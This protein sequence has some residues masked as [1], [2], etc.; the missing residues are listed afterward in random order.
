MKKSVVIISV[1]V[2][3]AAVAVGGMA[4][5]RR[6]ETA[7][8][9]AAAT[10]TAAAPA[11]PKTLELAASDLI[12]VAPREMRRTLPLTGQLRPSSQAVVRAK[13]AGE[14]VEM[15]VREGQAVKAG[16]V[17][18]RLEAADYKARVDEKAGALEANKA[19]FEYNEKTRRNNEELMRK[20]FISKNAYDNFMNSANVSQAQVRTAEAQL[21][22]ARKALEDTYVKAPISGVVSERA[23][24]LGDKAA[25]DSK[26]ISIVDLTRME[27]EAS[28]PAADIPSVSVGQEVRFTVEG[29][30]DKVFTGTI[31]RI[32][33]AAAAGSRSL[34]VYI[35]VPNPEGLLK[36][37]MFAKGG[38]T[39]DK[40][41]A[42]PAIPISAL[43]D[44]AGVQV[45][46]KVEGGKVLRV[47]VKTGVRNEEEGWVEITS[48]LTEGA[49]VVKANLGELRGDTPV[50]VVQK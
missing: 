29:F 12:A 10:A 4:M 5:K 49:Q 23:M 18:A 3:L 16:E 8:A 1:G 13:V 45:V 30:D 9:P 21:V 40:R 44:D 36:G 24:Q 22:Q 35:E 19:Q 20:N 17:L 2:V 26:L 25:V 14:I 32:N 31:A 47:P 6:S 42:V 11:G 46:Y 34:M 38:L 39:L 41:A 7:K 15:K 37:G 27:I 48:G 43:R 28:V 33:P 50:N